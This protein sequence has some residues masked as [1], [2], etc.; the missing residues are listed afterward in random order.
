ML[1]LNPDHVTLGAF[2][3]DHVESLIVDRAPHKSALEWSDIGPHLAFADVPEQRIDIRLTRRLTES[4]SIDLVP[5]DQV[6][7]VARRAPSASATGIVR[8]SASVVILSI[9]YALRRQGGATQT[10]HAIAI[11]SDGAVDP[12]NESE[13]ASE[14]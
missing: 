9:S 3:L 13:E 11:S 8:L 6:T 12:I 2:E 1:W 7:L 4:T 5:G 10:I 14:T